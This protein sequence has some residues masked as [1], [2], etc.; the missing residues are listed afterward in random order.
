M[1]PRAKTTAHTP[2]VD[3]DPYEY[4]AFEEMK[5]VG[6]RVVAS[7]ANLLRQALRSFAAHLGLQLPVQ[8]FALRHPGPGKRPRTFSPE[9]KAPQR[10]PC[11]AHPPRRAQPADH[12]WRR[13]H[14]LK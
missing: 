3:L 6:G 9:P 4:A 1:S 5:G 11:A 12:P 8:I 14:T 7:D 2:A 13:R 10:R